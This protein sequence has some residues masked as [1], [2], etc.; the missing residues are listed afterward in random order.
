MV[1]PQEGAR[2]VG[3]RRHSVAV[4]EACLG[5]GIITADSE[6]RTDQPEDR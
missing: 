1:V 3:D 2:G 5:N 6:R 4:P